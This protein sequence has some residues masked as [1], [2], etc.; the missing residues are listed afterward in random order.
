MC[1][2]PVSFTVMFLGPGS[3]TGGK[4]VVEVDDGYLS[5]HLEAEHGG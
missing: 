4:L 3:D 1:E 5:Q 2:Q